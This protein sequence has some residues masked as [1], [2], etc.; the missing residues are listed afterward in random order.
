VAAA[1]AEEEEEKATP[2]LPPPTPTT[3]TTA[4]TRACLRALGSPLPTLRTPLPA[5]LRMPLLR[6]LRKRPRVARAQRP[7]PRA[8]AMPKRTAP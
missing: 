8:C 4:P 3:T 1:A 5:P 2:L 7:R 6:L